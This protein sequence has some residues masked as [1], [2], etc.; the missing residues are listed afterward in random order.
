[1]ETREFSAGAFISSDENNGSQGSVGRSRRKAV[2]S[3]NVT[4]V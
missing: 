2:S 3:K 1:M 4:T